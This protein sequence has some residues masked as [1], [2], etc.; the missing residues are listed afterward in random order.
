MGF[1]M[2]HGAARGEINIDMIPELRLA[3]AHRRALGRLLQA[4]DLSGVSG[5][6]RAWAC[7]QGGLDKDKSFQKP[8][9]EWARNEC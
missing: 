4:V 9:Q 5:L 1:S 6:F 7:F 2:R 8:R 3:L